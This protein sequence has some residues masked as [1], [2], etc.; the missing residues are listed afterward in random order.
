MKSFIKTRL[1]LYFKGVAMGAADV[2]PGVSGGTI[3][4]ISGIYQELIDSIHYLKPSVLRNLKQ[5]GLLK[6]WQEINGTFLLV[7][8]LGIFTSV[9]SLSKVITYFLEHYPVLLWS[10]FFGLILASIVVIIRQI[11]KWNGWLVLGLIL[12]SIGSYYITLLEPS[13]QVESYGFLFL[14][15]FVA[16][17]AMILPG[18]S[19]AFI[20]LL[21]GSYEEVIGNLSLLSE[22]I[23]TGDYK[24]LFAVLLKLGTF[25]LGAIFG[26]KAFS[27]VLHWMFNHH[28]NITLGVLTGFMI[29]SLNKIWP[30]KI[31]LTTR[32]NSSGKEVPLLEKSILPSSYVGDSQIG[33]SVLLMIL[34]FML[35]IMLEYL[36]KKNKSTEV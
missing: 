18:I 14:S 19:G 24:A 1:L 30:W 25:G 13:A 16:I 28:K 33:Y 6:V 23:K 4:F 35:I 36:S 12:S 32:I 11:T 2:V 21:L 34:G 17:I 26:L 8:F 15:G 20:L 29:G 3:A 27:G 10:F 7:L 5:R 31:V 22:L 9:L